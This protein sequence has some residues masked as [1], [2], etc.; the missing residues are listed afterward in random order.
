MD[1]RCDL[2]ALVADA[3]VLADSAA[4]LVRPRD[5]QG[6]PGWTLPGEAL[7]HGEHPQACV[8][9]VLREQLG[10]TPEWLELAEVE[11]QPGDRWHLFFHYRCEAGG[12]PIPGAAIA[13][14]RFFQVEHLPE[15]AHGTWERDV[16]YR[17]LMG[18]PPA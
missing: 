2:H 15:T 16:I 11:S 3:V 9:R 5:P 18:A 14:T 10:L 1:K 8:E 17:V 13:E 4:L 12:P 6:R 7:R